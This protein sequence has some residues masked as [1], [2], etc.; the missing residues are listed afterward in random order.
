MYIVHTYCTYVPEEAGS[1]VSEGDGL[2]RSLAIVSLSDVVVV[3]EAFSTAFA[4]SKS[5]KVRLI[6]TISSVWRF[7]HKF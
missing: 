5:M 4:H 3:V 1:V 7:L 6:H 2:L